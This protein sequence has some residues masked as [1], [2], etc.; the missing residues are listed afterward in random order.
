MTLDLSRLQA[1]KSQNDA[2]A[3][4]KSR[5]AEL[6][7]DNTRT[8][9]VIVKS[10]AALADLLEQGTLKTAVVNQLTEIG[11][12]DALKVVAAIQSLKQTVEAQE[13][14]DL[15]EVTEVMRSILQEAKQI[16]KS[17][18]TI[19]I[20]KP[21][22]HA[23][24]FQSLES[25]VK[26]LEKAVKA[27][28]LK[29]EAPV[30]NV[31]ETNVNVEAPDLK[32]IS[33]SVVKSSKDVVKAVKAI[34]LPELNT[35]PLEK[36]LKKTNKLLGELPELMPTGGGGGS[37][38]VSPYETASGIP[39]FVELATDGSIP[40]SVT[41]PNKEDAIPYAEVLTAST[42]IT[43]S[44]GTRIQLLKSQVLQNP[45]NASANL[46]TL[47][48]VSTGDLVTGWAFSDSNEWVGEVDEDL[49]ITLGGSNPVS[50]NIRYKEI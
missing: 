17:H 30:V 11:T 15:S 21:I 47:S 10:I 41:D 33:D 49:N 5:H 3:V 38:R 36:L 19:D 39:A 14:T 2:D 32:P 18:N 29:V 22:D 16:P 1:I 27:Q 4:V 7:L 42:T 24:H 37:S 9:E 46:V 13:P 34:Q 23:K 20:P 6:L 48:F 28:E 31:P 35:E 50:V 26:S 45:D 8:Q 25:A 44:S 40:V 43:P 12:P